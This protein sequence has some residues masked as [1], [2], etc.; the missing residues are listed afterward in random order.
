VGGKCLVVDGNRAFNGAKVQIWDCKS[1]P[2]H[3]RKWFIAD[4]PTPPATPS[5]PTICPAG[6]TATTQNVNGGDKQW[7]NHDDIQGCADAC[8]NR[9]GCDV[10]EYA[11]SGGEKAKCGTYTTGHTMSGTQVSGWRTCS[12]S[13]TPPTP[14]PMDRYPPSTSCDQ[15]C[16]FKG[17]RHTCRDRVTWLLGQGQLQWEAILT[18][19]SDCQ[20]QCSCGHGNFRNNGHTR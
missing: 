11:V 7:S 15:A 14:P 10:F 1:V 16:F 9:H 3:Y 8:T 4:V 18:V 2:H 5:P 17:E 20:S 6:Y 13:S 19:N 12:K